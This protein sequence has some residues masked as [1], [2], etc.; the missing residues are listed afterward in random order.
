M[1]EQKQQKLEQAKVY[2]GKLANGYDPFSNA[3]LEND[4]VL[5]NVQLSRCFFF[6]YEVL[7]EAIQTGSVVSKG[8]KQ[9]RLPKFALPLSRRSAITTRKKPILITEL[10]DRIN[11][12]VNLEAMR[13]LK[14][15]AFGI[16]LIEKGF[17]TIVEKDNNKY[18]QP[19]PEGEKIGIIAEWVEYYG[20]GYNR[21]KFNAEAQQFLI[22]NLDEIIEISNGK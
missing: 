18:K 10:C 4:S 3:L 1:D 2:I 19:T 11:A 14:V 20:Q 12:A 7:Q 13:K 17:L 16:W 22:D 21:L 15:T 5:N 9:S 6:I 8:V